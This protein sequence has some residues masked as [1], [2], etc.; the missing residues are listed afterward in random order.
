MPDT[1]VDAGRGD[2]H[3]DIAGADDRLVDV[4]E[5]Q[6]VRWAVSLLHDCPHQATVSSRRHPP[7]GLRPEA[8]Q[9]EGLT[10]NR[11]RNHRENAL[12]EVKPSRSETSVSE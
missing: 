7:A 3:Q 10:P 5:P 11:W 8:R 4:A 2:P 1:L 12:G 9:S 6:H